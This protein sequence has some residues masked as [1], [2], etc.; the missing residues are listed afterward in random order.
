MRIILYARDK[1]TKK[2]T[3]NCLADGNNSQNATH[4]LS[5]RP[6]REVP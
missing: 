2:G 6:K 5:L 4:F 1:K 3:K